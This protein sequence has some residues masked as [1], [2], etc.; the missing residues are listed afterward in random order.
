MGEPRRVERVSSKRVWLHGPVIDLAV[1]LL[2][3]LAVAA[4]ASAGSSEGTVV[5]AGRFVLGDTTHVILTFVLLGTRTEV[6]DAAK[7]QR[8][9]VIVGGLLVFGASLWLFS[10][11]GWLLVLVTYVWATVHRLGQFRGV[12]SLHAL[13]AAQAGRP[14]PS[15]AERLAQR[16]VLPVGVALMVV[17]GFVGE[18]H[19]LFGGDVAG[20]PGEVKWLVVGAWLSLVAFALWTMRGAFRAEA[21]PLYVGGV[22]L[23]VAAMLWHPIWGSVVMGGIHGL[24]YAALSARM[25]DGPEGRWRRWGLALIAVGSL[26]VIGFI[27]RL[28][29][30]SSLGKGAIVAMSALV[31]AH[32]FV[33]GVIYRLRIPGVRAVMLERL[34]L[35]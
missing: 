17:R 2:P 16:A 9:I 32:Y 34:R 4:F 11:G 29:P 14:A 21:K 24:E 19:V 20:L 10:F 33:D 5:W 25:L 1:L 22:G 35:A 3:A 15:S 31:L 13:A 12:W 7:G 30:E 8:A 23:A 18:D 26:L 27:E 6:L 28:G